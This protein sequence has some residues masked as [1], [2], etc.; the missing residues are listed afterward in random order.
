MAVDGSGLWD[1]YL[2]MSVERKRELLELSRQTLTD[3]NNTPIAKVS[4]VA[5]ITVSLVGDLSPFWAALGALTPLGAR[6]TAG[7]LLGLL[8]PPGHRAPDPIGPGPLPGPYQRRE[9]SA[10][11]CQDCSG[12]GSIHSHQRVA[13][14]ALDF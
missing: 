5:A 4:R 3:L 11:W 2:V 13:W 1:A 9:H 12:R 14:S 7:Y 10:L 8:Q 6:S